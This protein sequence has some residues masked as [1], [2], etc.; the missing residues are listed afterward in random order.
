[1][2]DLRLVEAIARL[3]SVGA[4]AREL[5]M[6][7][8]TASRRLVALEARLSIG[9]FHRDTTGARA[10]AVGAELARHAARLLRD[11]DDLPRHL[12]DATAEPV[13]AA[14]SIQSLSPMVFTALALELDEM[15][16]VPE[17]DH[18]PAIMALVERKA[19]DAAFVT[20]AE[21]TEVPRGLARMPVGESPFVLVLP[22]YTL[23]GARGSRRPLLGRTVLYNTIDLASE[24][25]K[26]RLV[27]LGARPQA[28]TTVDATLRVARHKRY[29][30][31]VPEFVA[32]WYAAKGDR[33]VESPVPGKVN[34]SVITRRPPPRELLAVLPA[35]GRR[36]LGESD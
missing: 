7:Q 5:L 30:A 13:L 29:P 25:V 28:L 9:L 8:P 34:I 14:G 22:A 18:G 27:A 21:Q 4:A 36:V 35:I 3:G 23:P 32:R 10:T 12:L 33:I 6:S 26:A 2:D 16:I 24:N 11:L 31:L 17:V 20:I 15:T 1:M 19:L